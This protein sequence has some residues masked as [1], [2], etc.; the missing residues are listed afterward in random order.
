MDCRVAVLTLSL[1][2]LP[3]AVAG[4]AP[5]APPARAA[6]E[7]PVWDEGPKQLALGHALT[8]ELPEG[9]ISLPAGPAGKLLEKMGNFRNENLLAVVTRP[10]A[11]WIITVRYIDD[12]YVRD[13]E[14]DKLDPDQILD[15]I[16]E[17]TEQGN[18]LRKEKGFPPIHVDGWTDVPRYDR[19]LH[20]VIWGTKLSSERG[21]SDNFTTR[22]LGRKGLV[23]LNLVGSPE[24]IPAAKPYLASILGATHFDSGSRYQ[25]FQEGKDKVAEYGL[26]ALIAGGAGAAALKIAKVGILA[27]LSTKIIAILIAGKKLV[28]VAVA[29]LL[30]LL[31][32]L[33]GKKSSPEVPPTPA[34]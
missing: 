24:Q 18:V 1:A 33:F 21:V 28:L 19:G 12:G 13:D 4:P 34:P 10:D 11:K 3:S 26:A 15:A 30:A 29:G 23:A 16:K 5:A 8:M 20:H 22:I 9:F 32:K 2:V 7:R 31:K 27:K 17:G 6:E 14:A 25:D